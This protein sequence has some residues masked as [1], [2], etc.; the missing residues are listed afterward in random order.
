MLKRLHESQTRLLRCAFQLFAFA[1]LLAGPQVCSAQARTTAVTQ[2]AHDLCGKQL[3]LLGE[4]DHGDGA[5]VEFKAALVQRLVSKCGFSAVY[6]E[7]GTYD[8]LKM[9]E[10]VR[11]R[12]PVDAAMLASSIG[13]LWNRD[14]ELKTL[15]DFLLPQVNSGAVRVGGIDD[16]IGAAGAFYSLGQLPNDLASILPQA[17]RIDCAEQM[18]RRANYDF[19]DAHPHDAA[20]IASLDRCLADIQQALRSGPIDSLTEDRLQMVSEFRRAI[21]RDFLPIADFIPRRDRGMYDDLR[22][23]MDH[24]GSHRKAIVWTANAHAAKSAAIG[25]EYR[26]APNLGTLV[27]KEFGSRVFA[28]G[29][30]AENGSHYWSRSDPTRPIP[31]A[32][33]DSIESRALAGRSVDA[34][35]VSE[36][37]LK[38][39]GAAPASF[40]LHHPHSEHWDEIFDG[41]VILRTERPPLRTP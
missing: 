8:F 22:W 39:L 18:R 20:S 17:R 41:A 35:Y 24:A 1:W 28:L 31:A 36:A 10:M 38:K 40:D 6:F 26:K 34:V 21:A 9:E 5:T 25:D 11:A 33:P 14:E 15:I 3:V 4:A 32:A 19:S 13:A 7:A 23:L 16:Q 12:Q 30:S 29:I 27:H 2:A 37:Q